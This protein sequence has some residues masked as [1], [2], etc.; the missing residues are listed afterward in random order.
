[1]N[2][3]QVNVRSERGR[4]MKRILPKKGI[5]LTMSL[6][7]V[8]ATVMVPGERSTTYAS[9]V[10]AKLP[11]VDGDASEWEG[12]G[13][14]QGSSSEVE[15]WKTVKGQDYLYV[16][17]CG[18]SAN[19]W[20]FSYA[21]QV[22]L[23]CQYDRELGWPENTATALSV[24][25]ENDGAVVRNSSYGVVEG[26]LGSISNGA[27][28]N[29]PG[30]YV[31]EFAVPLS[32]FPEG[33]TGL[34]LGNDAA[35]VISFSDI[36]EAT[37]QTDHPSEP[38]EPV[39]TEE[40]VDTETSTEPEGGQE[41]VDTP[42]DSGEK[43]EDYKG[44]QIDG[45]FG[46]W[47]AVAKEDAKCPNQGHPDCLSKVA[48]VWD[49]DWMYLYIEE[50]EGQSAA[51]A[52][53][54]SNGKYSISSDLGDNVLFQLGW[55]SSISGVDGAQ[56]S[57]V[58][59]QWEIAIPKSQFENCKWKESFQFGLYLSDP[60]ITGITDLQ[61]SQENS[62]PVGE[63]SCD[64]SYEEWNSLPHAVIQYDTAG[65][66]EFKQDGKAA[67]YSDGESLYGHVVTEHPDHLKEA[68]GEFL[69]AITVKFNVSDPKTK[70]DGYEF[71]PRFVT[72]DANGNIDWNVKPN[73]YEP[74]TYEFY[75]MSLDA[76]GN[77]KNINE[78]TPGDHIYGKMIMTI[79]QNGRDEMEFQLYLADLAEKFGCDQSSLKTIHA[80][81]GR[82]GGQWV[83]CA[84]TS[85]GPIV[86]LALSL[87]VVVAAYGLKKRRKI[88]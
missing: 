42:E 30:P 44:I 32:Y 86:G 39:D 66:H 78:L 21:G 38:E 81:F 27:N 46:D 74:G 14:I 56:V 36:P 88:M 69:S 51:G 7:L 75:V 65:T 67:L 50:G 5:A 76:W 31:V 63:M 49:G 35:N 52:G 23:H 80:Q 70:S 13:A 34:Y 15:Q 72:V 29:T 26:A 79:G 2:R 83:S 25:K 28:W 16:M 8:M 57:H 55:D 47:N 48:A 82:I 1:M 11:V 6:M 58:G 54:H 84:G 9:E 43:L 19:Q 62:T 22:V 37:I 20:D 18:T 41:P 64:G 85:T 77:S 87:G 3:E 12:L 71:G 45:S 40:A 4:R 59:T 24:T 17:Y 33:L 60:F 68:G 53:T 73:H 61:N 10:A